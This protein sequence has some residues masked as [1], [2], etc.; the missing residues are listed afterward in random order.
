MLSGF[1]A[2]RRRER[3]KN[4][5]KWAKFGGET[6][7]KQR[8]LSVVG[9]RREAEERPAPAPPTEEEKAAA[10]AEAEQRRVE[11]NEAFKG[12]DYGAAIARYTEALGALGA[13]DDEQA[14]SLKAAVHNNRAMAFLSSGQASAAAADASV[15]LTLQPDNPKALFRRALARRKLGG[16][17]HCQAAV[18]D[19]EA[20]C[21]LQ[22]ANA[23]A[24]LWCSWRLRAV[25]RQGSSWR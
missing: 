10:A 22:P 21:A 11:G 25:S 5:G 14:R 3:A 2:P 20:V 8:W 19:L 18:D 12:G 7:E 24:A 13:V 23:A 17:T 15:V 1:L 9:D 4:G 16:A 6:G